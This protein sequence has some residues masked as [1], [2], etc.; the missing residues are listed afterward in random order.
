MGMASLTEYIVY[1][2]I[3]AYLPYGRKYGQFIPL[4]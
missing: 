1:V 3:I 2:N 4:P